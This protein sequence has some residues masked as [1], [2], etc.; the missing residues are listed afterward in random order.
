M[1]IYTRGG[2]KGDT[3]LLGGKRVGKDDLRVESYG[4]VDELN[5]ALGMV[6]AS[7]LE[8]VL[9]QH[10]ERIEHELFTVCSRLAAA[11]G[12]DLSRIPAIEQAWID[13]LEHEID[14]ATAA[15]PPLRQFVLPGGSVPA[16]WLHLARTICRRAERVVVRLARA[17]EV[18][19][20]AIAYL[21]RLSDWLFVMARL[22]N[23]EAGARELFWSP[24]KK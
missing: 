20:L 9:A 16:S 8:P 5:A 14:E 7:G 10:V 24:P 18:E 23:Q 15:L 17:E 4:T 3:D 2:D 1:K 12:A 6:C 22:A 21:N 11:P 19:P 13:R